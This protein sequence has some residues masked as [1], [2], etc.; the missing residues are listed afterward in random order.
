MSSPAPPPAAS[1]SP[2]PDGSADGSLARRLGTADAA[3]IGVGSMIGAGVFVAFAPA[4]AHAGALLP[5]ALLLAAVVAWCNATSTAQL[6][7]VH[8]ASGGA[9]VYA[10][11]QLG[12]WAG[13]A[14]GW[15][16]VTGK[17]AS[18]AGMSMAV[19]LYVAAALGIDDGAAVARGVAVAAIAALTCVNL[20][21]ITRTAGLT[22]LLVGVVLLILAVVAGL[23]AAA[24]SIGPVGGAAPR[25]EA[26]AAE[27][28]GVLT[29]A[30]LL[31]FA[32]AGYARVATMGEEVRD[33]QR[34]IPRAILGALAFVLVVYLVL[35]GLLLGLLGAGG[36][37]VSPAPFVSASEEIAVR[38][39]LGDGAAAALATAVA[40]AAA[41]G[42]LGALLALIAGIS[43]TSLA[44]ARERDLP[45]FLRRISDRKVP[46]AAE[47]TTAMLVIGL[48]AFT[49]LH[50]VIGFSSFGVLVYYALAN[51][52]ALTLRERP[53]WAPRALNIVGLIGCLLLAFTLPWQS[54]VVMLAVFAVGFAGRA[55]VLSR[56]G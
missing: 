27:L 3:I 53:R 14:A 25:P 48:I 51:L 33:P 6:A 39:G 35:A 29:A 42:A 34:S 16:F 13:F 8:P 22:R 17:T 44:M 20:G 7:M 37:A 15:G 26:G 50:T 23:G 31:F 43:R 47:L 38:L 12:P 19:G 28:P 54:V 41:A 11:R 18:A 36:L 55:A 9:Y 1:A 49:D 40:V 30:G 10:N 2:G 56:R 5:A 45:G 4:A 24:L 52:S 32:F 46:W 21:G